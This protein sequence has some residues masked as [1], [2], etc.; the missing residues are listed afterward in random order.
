[1]VLA[2]PRAPSACARSGA[3]SSATSAPTSRRPAPPAHGPCSCP[4]AVT[5]P[6]EVAARPGGRRPTSSRA[7]GRSSS[8][9]R[10]GRD[11]RASWPSARP[12]R[13][14]SDGDVLLAGPA[15][16]PLAADATPLHLLVSPA[17]GRRGRAAARRR[18]GARGRTR[19]G[20]GRRRRRST[21][22]PLDALLACCVGGRYDEVVVLTSFHQSPLPLALLA[23]VAGVPAWPARA[24][25]TPGSLLDVRHRGRR[26]TTSRWS[27]RSRGSR[28]CALVGRPAIPGD[29]GALRVAA[30][31]R[32]PTRAFGRGRTS[33]CTPAP[34]SR[35]APG[36]PSATP[37]SSRALVAGGR[38]VVVTGGAGGA[39]AHR[40]RGGRRHRRRRPRRAHEPLAE[41]AAVLAGPTPSSSAT[42]GPAHLAAAVGTPVVSLF[43]PDRAAR[44][45]GARGACRTVV[46]GDQ[47]RPV[48]R[49]VAREP[50]RSPA[51]RA[52][53]GWRSATSSPPSGPAVRRGAA[54]PREAGGM[55]VLLWHVHGSWTTALVG[56]D[57]RVPASRSCP[58]AGP[59][60]AA[61]PARGTGRLGAREVTP[62]AAARRGRRRRRPPAP[63]RARDLAERWLGR[64]AGRD[65]AAVYVEHNAPQ[66]RASPTAQPAPDRSAT[67][68]RRPMLVVVPRDALQRAHRGTA[69]AARPSRRR[70]RHRDPGHRYTGEPTAA[71]GRHQRAASAA[72]GS[73]APT[74][75]RA[76]RARRA[77]RRL[78]HGH[79][80]L[81][82]PRRATGLPG[83][84]PQPVRRPAA[85]RACT[86]ELAR[87]PGLPAP[88]SAGLARALAARGHAPGDAG[89]S[90]WPT[91]E[92]PEAV[93]P[94]AGVLVTN[95]RRRLAGDCAA[96]RRRARRGPRARAGG[97][98]AHGPRPLRPHAGS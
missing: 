86:S 62:D 28:R 52:S 36:R 18:R 72:A 31:R 73:P 35:P 34:R 40:R 3:S 25:T 76:L 97:R 30:R 82:R 37:A 89:A 57:A 79:R 55:R 47:R 2:R 41:L 96:A 8:G 26:T 61:G 43:A 24:T 93:P 68:A 83:H 98:A 56:G 54:P 66:G 77:A 58:T 60:A 94:S 91:T 44:V 78:R 1:M 6:E 38:R 42:P 84:R 27:G 19:R 90:R 53:A 33:S 46:L 12:V 29:D 64:R 39:G 50:A 10:D 4:R 75:A 48:R 70:A 16:G 17:R 67:T 5:R 7:V 85:G 9:W 21:R 20:S 71:R 51:T 13:L 49:L 87:R 59:T 63:A 92:A 74:S 88:R 45:A 80:R 69:A 14:D 95:D 22:P 23:Q 81:E 15:C 32:R 11:S 65:V